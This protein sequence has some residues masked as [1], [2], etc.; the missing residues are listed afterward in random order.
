MEKINKKNVLFFFILK[1]M[2]LILKCCLKLKLNFSTAKIAFLIFN[3]SNK[4]FNNCSFFFWQ[5]SIAVF[6]SAKINKENFSIFD[7]L[8]FELKFLKKRKFINIWNLKKNNKKFLHNFKDMVK[9]TQKIFLEKLDFII[10]FKNFFKFDF[11]IL[12]S[13]KYFKNIMLFK[14][15]KAFLEYQK[16]TSKLLDLFFFSFFNLVI[17]NE[18]YFS[19]NIWFNVKNKKIDYPKRWWR[20]FKIRETELEYFEK[21]SVFSYCLTVF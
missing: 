2:I 5:I 13:L 7:S 18:C 15:V 4:I 14:K 19:G 10:Y 9:K 3:L 16:K 12:N 6:F 1:G 21:N 8:L 20:I 17:S 11:F